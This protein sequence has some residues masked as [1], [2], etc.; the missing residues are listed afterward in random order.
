M[1]EETEET[2]GNKTLKPEEVPAA[3]KAD[4]SPTAGPGT[5]DLLGIGLRGP[6]P[7]PEPIETF[8]SSEPELEPE[9]KL[10]EVNTKLL[11]DLPLPAFQRITRL[12]V[13]GHVAAVENTRRSL[14]FVRGTPTLYAAGNVSKTKATDEREELH[15]LGEMCADGRGGD[16]FS[17]QDLMAEVRRR[18]EVN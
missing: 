18:R 13:G 8:E 15:F 17:I 7:E 4:A 12:P 16:V 1:I 9:P 11:A 14:M 5:P 6:E 10:V 2:E 3:D